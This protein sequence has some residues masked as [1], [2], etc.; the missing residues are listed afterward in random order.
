MFCVV[1]PR[2]YDSPDG[3]I[4]TKSSS[5]GK[6]TIS[7]NS[8]RENSPALLLDV[9]SHSNLENHKTNGKLES[10]SS[11]PISDILTFKRVQRLEEGIGTNS[12]NIIDTPGILDPSTG[13]VLTVG[14]AIRLRILDVRS[15]KIAKSL[16]LKNKNNYV[17][18][19]EAVKLGLVNSS[20][21]NRLLGPCG[22]VED[23]H[24]PQLSLLEA[25]QRELMDAERGP[26]DRVKVHI[27]DNDENGDG[28]KGI[29]ISK[30]IVDE[31]VS[32]ETA[33]HI[34]SHK[35]QADGALSL[36][37]ALSLGIIDGPSATFLNRITGEKHSLPNALKLGFLNG[38]I[39]EIVEPISDIKMTT[40]EALEKG[41]LKNGH[42]NDTFTNEKLTLLEAVRK[43]LI[44][45][46][47]T[48][49]DCV[50]LDLFHESGQ[51]ESATCRSRA[52]IL[53]GIDSGILDYNLTKNIVN[54]MDD[55]IVSLEDALKE[56]I[57]L[58][59]GLYKD[60]KNEEVIPI[61]TAVER[62]F[63]TSFSIK[64]LFDIEGFK[65]LS[66]ENYLSLNQALRKNVL[67]NGEYV[68]NE[69]S[70]KSI[71]LNEAVSRGFV[72][73]EVLEMLNQKIGIFHGDKE[74]SVL[75]AV[76]KNYID[77]ESGLIIDQKTKKLLPFEESVRKNLITPEGASLLHSLL[78]INL[79][80]QTVT[81]NNF[82]NDTS[83][84]ED[85]ISFE[86]ARS[87][88]LVDESNKTFTCPTSGV[89]I[90]LSVA[91]EKG[92]LTHFPSNLVIT[93]EPSVKDFL[94]KTL[95][96]FIPKNRNETATSSSSQ[97]SSLECSPNKIKTH[98]SIEQEG[99][100]KQ[101]FELPPDG[102]FL[103]EAVEKKLFD[104]VTGLFIIPGTDR[105]VSFE[106]CIL[107]E[108]INS[109][110]A[111]V[112]DPSKK[113]HISIN[114]ALEKK[115][116]DSTGHFTMNGIK[117]TLKEAI[118]KNYVL[119]ETRIKLD[120]NISRL[121][122]VTKVI[123][124]PDIV[125]VSEAGTDPNK[126]K[127]IKISDSDFSLEPLQ[128]SPGVIFD[129]ATALVIFTD[130]GNSSNLFD[131][132]KDSSIDLSKIKVKEPHTGHYLSIDEAIK[133]GIME[134]DTGIYIDN[135]GRKID[136]NNA[137]KFGVISVEGTPLVAVSISEDITKETLEEIKRVKQNYKRSPSD[138]Q[139]PPNLSSDDETFF[140]KELIRDEVSTEPK[141]NVSIETAKT[142]LSNEKSQTKHVILHKMRRKIIEPRDAVTVGILNENMGA[143]LDQKSSFI[144][145]NGG[146]LTLA[147]AI[148]LGK[149][150]GSVGCVTDPQRGDIL[151][152]TEAI[153]RGYLDPSANN[154]NLLIPIAKSLSVPEL[155]DQG[156]LENGKIIHPES[157]TLLNLKEAIVCDIV[158]PFSNVVDNKTGQKIPL[159]TAI[160]SGIIDDIKLNVIL[161]NST[162]DLLAAVQSGSVFEVKNEQ[163]V[164]GMQPVGMTLN[165]A[166]DRRLIDPESK[167][168]KHPVTGENKPI[169]KALEKDFL[170]AVPSPKTHDSINLIDALDLNLIDCDNC[171]FR[172]PNTGETLKI[173]EAVESGLLIIKESKD[174]FEKLG[175]RLVQ[176]EDGTNRPLHIIEAYD[177]LYDKKS[178]K[179]R[180]PQT[181][182]KLLSLKSA[183]D[184]GIIDSNSVLLDAVT[185]NS[186]T[187]TDAIKKGLIDVKTGRFKNKDDMSIADAAKLGL[188]AVIGAPILAG[189]AVVNAIKSNKDQLEN[190]SSR[191]KTHSSPGNNSYQNDQV[192][193]E[194]IV[195]VQ[196]SD[197]LR[198]SEEH[199][200][201]DNHDSNHE[202]SETLDKNVINANKPKHSI[203]LNKY[204][205][206]RDFVLRHL[207]DT[208][209]K[210]YL[211]PHTRE[212][213]SF[214]ELVSMKI[215][216]P[217]FLVKNIN[218]KN[219]FVTLDEALKMNLINSHDG[220]ISDT[221][222][223]KEVTFFEAIRLGWIKPPDANSNIVR[224]SSMT[225]E[226]A[227]DN[228]LFDVKTC[229]VIDPVSQRR[230]SF[231]EAVLTGLL[232]PESISIRKSAS[233]DFYSLPKAVELCILDLNKSLINENIDIPSAFQKGY[234]LP[235]PR[236][237]VSLVHIVNNEL[238]SP[239]S[240]LISDRVTKMEI[241]LHEAINRFIVDPFITHVKDLKSNQYLSLDE[242]ISNNIIDAERGKYVNPI[243]KSELTFDNA[244]QKELIVTKFITVTLIEALVQGFYNNK[245]GHFFNPVL[246]EEQT[247][248]NCI[249]SGFID[250]SSSH[251]KDA[252][253]DEMITVREAENKHII[254]LNRGILLYPREM[255]LDIALEKGF[256]LSSRKPWSL[257]EAL[258]HKVYDPNSKLLKASNGKAVTLEEAIILEEINKT[259]LSVKDPRS[260]DIM[261]LADA[262]KIGIIDAKSNSATN[263][264]TG[265][266][267]DFNEALEQGLLLPAKRKL[268]FPEA[269][270]KGFY[271][272]SSGKFSSSHT[273]EKLPTDKAIRHGFIDAASI[274]IKVD[275]K[276]LAFE[277]A[278]EAG[279]VDDKNGS[280]RLDGRSINFQ[281]ALENGVIIEVKRPL[282]ISEAISKGLYDSNSGL[283]LD[284]WNESYYT[285]A[286]AIDN[287]LIDPDSV[288]VKDPRCE[289]WKRLSLV[290]AIKL[291]IINGD[292]GKLQWKGNNLFL[293]E[294][295]EM[296]LI[297][298]S[299]EAISLQKAIHQGLYDDETGKI[300]DPQTCRK[301][302]LQGAIEI[303]LINS[304]LPCFWNKA[305]CQLLSLAETCRV[306]II[307]KRSGMFKEPGSNFSITLGDALQLGLIVDIENSSFGLYEAICM[308]MCNDGLV[309]NPATGNKVNLKTAISEDLINPHL[310][311][312]KNSEQNVYVKLPEA[313]E[314]D[315]ID[316]VKGVYK[317]KNSGEI[318]SLVEAK[319]RNLILTAK[320]PLSIEEALLQG[321]YNEQTGCFTDPESN[322]ELNLKEASL[323]NLV[324]T[325]KTVIKLYNGQVKPYSIAVEEGIIDDENGRIFNPEDSKSYTFTEALREGLLSTVEVPLIFEKVIK[326]KSDAS[327]NI[328]NEASTLT[329]GEAV[330]HQLIDPDIAVVK[331]LNTA[332]FNP[333]KKAVSKG[334][335]DLNKKVDVNLKNGNITPPNITL[336]QNYVLYLQEPLSFSEAVRSGSLNTETGQFCDPNSERVFSLREALL[337][338]LVD[339][340]SAIVKETANE[341]FY[342]LPE[343][344]KKGLISTDNSSVLDTQSSRLYTL[345]E[346]FDQ[347]LITTRSVSLLEAIDYGLYNPTN[348]VI[349]DPFSS[350]NVTD[351]RRLNLEDALNSKLVDPLTTVIKNPLDGKISSIPVAVSSQLLDVK[352][353]RFVD[354]STNQSIDLLKAR[355]RGYI[356]PSSARVSVLQFISYTFF[357]A[358]FFAFPLEVKCAWTFK[359]IFCFV[360][361]F[362]FG[363]HFYHS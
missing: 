22:I 179:F 260:G 269:V 362:E 206:P 347:N 207:Y 164:V 346:A 138:E 20:L 337:N 116:L 202:H 182:G 175:I 246:G 208:N 313:V 272:P 187:T 355:D 360:V 146:L 156:L 39:K 219:E 52:S 214:C 64:S 306:G 16:D 55:E 197:N 148:N 76:I 31:L 40:S 26:L 71:P 19:Q 125:E 354:P 15:G 275:D 221:L 5:S 178:N 106:E 49:K 300:I 176:N 127:E 163:N 338:G 352:A 141:H 333:F 41:L 237:P 248:Q 273:K 28:S 54:T 45:K 158:D 263:P 160:K 249:D 343:A 88:G 204:T 307:D 67:I 149:I 128:I 274:I 35:N 308:G 290:E 165:V 334:L 136:F 339:P 43:R 232:N 18:I 7:I 298:H 44:I 234:I 217:N 61:K 79:T 122:K 114:R 174:L 69:D 177:L 280:I 358:F 11:T 168:I 329:I 24:K 361:Q 150:D 111:V 264:L 314:T 12:A 243:D 143:K 30:A 172:N 85:A 242:S 239:K 194:N 56:N 196:P 195:R 251:I 223:G 209:S 145:N 83:D 154:G 257:Q 62:G 17:S 190:V 73:P 124:K 115:V 310:S 320:R 36:Y 87:L 293:L 215:L 144:S 171:T 316:D 105:L 153:N 299:K 13:Q 10:N 282:S 210:S 250:V 229:E 89:K 258:V 48:L 191:S 236:K 51:I 262:I 86:K 276:L 117:M 65:D 319:D 301:M 92:L 80:T 302:T 169:I 32:V 70:T 97:S 60:L 46:P 173:Q 317:Y 110:S 93:T 270:I 161:E 8:S 139:E 129:P 245:S 328:L 349:T 42:Y 6:V 119:L 261:T 183:I 286:E 322:T 268:S 90:P 356:L 292:T 216:D 96:A 84:P 225:F 38:N 332:E 227:L 211:N 226:E 279:I 205:T 256:I 359:C 152:I 27:I 1:S 297:N 230:L 200:G 57:I 281:Q 107:F 98:G 291:D 289:A 305:D 198:E 167:M 131:V 185:G 353:G 336:D 315:L 318:L 151:S 351:K 78:S 133:K 59:N 68:T 244:V 74:L 157:G 266:V 91:V 72:R 330:R 140:V 81:K 238:Y 335:V 23:D 189:R 240:G 166:L 283:F 327:K 231:S 284:P 192:P 100:E 296:G 193:K 247:L 311:I 33:Q 181:P 126:F 323:M 118:E 294:A 288:N 228:D 341:K 134:E 82:Q 188:L 201:N 135:S 287:R 267:L 265:E 303:S 101:V 99:L 218:E 342:K 142:L 235:R 324:N 63:L 95:D 224:R 53:E 109:K 66:S 104:P 132:M 29:S 50:D 277:H 75:G 170:M 259:A 113:R 241:T 159:A 348:G 186:Y 180:D 203:I 94:I 102:W 34:T 123:G 278:V 285:L 47:L 3:H 14:D 309:L 345:Q 199:R 155:V 112:L 130:S 220:F 331:N 357:S 304:S 37:D 321:L 4:Q 137:V 252:H 255:T 212:P 344:Y 312:V 340:D 184:S 121:I 162:I 2:S 350:K 295:F 108:I 326:R 363:F 254:D 9:D 253:Q 25:I 58:P 213:T 77:P 147:E 271:D 222:T 21:A 233:E 103:Q 120:E 325:E